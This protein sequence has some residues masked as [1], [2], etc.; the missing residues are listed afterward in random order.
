MVVEGDN[1]QENDEEDAAQNSGAE[2]LTA[3]PYFFIEHIRDEG[4]ENDDQDI[5]GGFGL[6]GDSH[7]KD[8]ESQVFPV[9]ATLQSTGAGVGEEKEHGDKEDVVVDIGKVERELG[10]EREERGNDEAHSGGESN[11]A[12]REVSEENSERAEKNREYSQ[13]VEADENSLV[14][15]QRFYLGRDFMVKGSF[16][17]DFWFSMVVVWFPDSRVYSW[18]IYSR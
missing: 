2:I 15:K 9:E 7:G 17:C 1:R 5:A 4:H 12:G 8:E 10:L 18:L 3:S 11:G 6:G 14:G 16:P 13:E